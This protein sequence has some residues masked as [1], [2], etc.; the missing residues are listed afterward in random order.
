[1]NGRFLIRWRYGDK[2]RSIERDGV[3]DLSEFI[4][5]SDVNDREIL[6]VTPV[7]SDPEPYRYVNNSSIRR[8]EPIVGMESKYI[9]DPREGISA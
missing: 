7:T 2:V 3:G 8:A 1:M 9:F 5:N 6:S 4:R